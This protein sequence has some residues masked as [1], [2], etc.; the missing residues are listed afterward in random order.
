MSWNILHIRQLWRVETRLSHLATT[1]EK[2]GELTGRTVTIMFLTK[3]GFKNKTNCGKLIR[4]GAGDARNVVVS[5]T[6][7]LSLLSSEA[8]VKSG[9]IP[10]KRVG[11]KTY[12]A[13]E[14]DEETS[15]NVSR[16]MERES[17]IE[18]YRRRTDEETSKKRSRERERERERDQKRRERQGKRIWAR[19]ILSETLFLFVSPSH[20]FPSIRARSFLLSFRR[21]FW[22]QCFSL[23][24]PA[25]WP[26]VTYSTVHETKRKRSRATK[27]VNLADESSC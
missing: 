5:R 8:A 4:G 17:A 9:G 25:P 7:P 12:A 20:F 11:K 6:R 19:W 18:V 2:Y 16:E 27:K 14:R 3:H 21:S 15:G 1:F 23:F 10:E 13:G 26:G 24:F 22:N